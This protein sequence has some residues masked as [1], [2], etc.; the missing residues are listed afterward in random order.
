M[1]ENDN[2]YNGNPGMDS[3][4]DMNNMNGTNNMN[5]MNNF[6]NSNNMNN[7]ANNVDIGQQPVIPL[8]TPEMGGP[9]YPGDMDEEIDIGQQPVVPLPTPEMGGPVYPGP[10]TPNRPT[11]SRPSIPSRPT[12]SFPSFPNRP[13]TPSTPTFPGFNPL[14][15]GQVRFINAST[16]NFPVNITID[17]TA[18][19]TNSRF[20]DVTGYDWIS[21]GFHTVTVRRATG[22]RSILLQQNFPFM[23]GQKV[24][25]VLTDSASGGLELV[26]VVDTGCTNMPFNTGCYRFANMTYSGSRFDLLLYGGETVF[27][28]V[29]FQTVTSY[30]QAMAGSYQF[31]I[32]ASNTYTFIRELPI[33]VVGVIGTSS[34]VQQPLV[35]FLL[36]INA[37]VNYTS[38][39]IG[40]TWSDLGLRVIT[41]ED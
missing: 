11:P 8:P 31:Y 16:N 39:L 40:N 12:P 3:M 26:R 7:Q 2:H 32:T 13:I 14:Y 41:L 6:N 1:A 20:G 36:D 30:K 29:G 23:S 33:I 22:L 25:M 24:T 17:G 21:D 9:V 5:S 38:Y 35:S 4:D 15:F 28:N 37:G 18:Y 34:N 19:A 27:R 10:S